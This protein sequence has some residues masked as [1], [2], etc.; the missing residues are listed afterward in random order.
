MNYGRSYLHVAKKQSKAFVQNSTLNNV[1]Q[2]FIHQAHKKP[3]CACPTCE[4]LVICLICLGSAVVIENQS[5][6]NEHQQ[7]KLSSRRITPSSNNKESRVPSGA[8]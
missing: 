2:G 1:E 4:M 3:S 5:T 7:K 8:P 6:R